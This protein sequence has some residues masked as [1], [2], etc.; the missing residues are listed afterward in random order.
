MNF[1]IQPFIH[2]F[3]PDSIVDD[4]GD[5]EDSCLS[6]PLYDGATINVGSAVALMMVFI[7]KFKLSGAALSSLIQLICL[8]LP[9][10]HCHY[11]TLKKSLTKLHKL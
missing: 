4:N 11:I 6:K 7:Q 3:Y 10:S 1:L 8:L 9:A 5:V 2:L